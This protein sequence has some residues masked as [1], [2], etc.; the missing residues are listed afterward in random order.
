MS[1]LSKPSPTTHTCMDG[2]A[3][4]EAGVL[5]HV[6]AMLSCV[7]PWDLKYHLILKLNQQ[8]SELKKKEKHHMPV[9][10]DGFNQR[11]SSA[12]AQKLQN[13]LLTS[14]FKNCCS[15]CWVWESYVQWYSSN[16]Q[17]PQLKPRTTAKCCTSSA[18]VTTGNFPYTLGYR[19]P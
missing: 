5:L 19:I 11:I 2:P 12:A 6:P 4:E 16:E 7:F 9:C 3:P 8:K 18:S 15:T 14:S 10:N 1:C 13:P 17:Q